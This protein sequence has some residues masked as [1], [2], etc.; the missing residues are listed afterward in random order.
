MNP[1]RRG[2]AYPFRPFAT[3]EMSFPPQ[4]AYPMPEGPMPQGFMPEGPTPGGFMPGIPMSANS[5]PEGPMPESFMPGDQMPERQEMYAPAMTRQNIVTPEPPPINVNG[6][7]PPGLMG[8]I[9]DGMNGFAEGNNMGNFA[10]MGGMNEEMGRVS[11]GMGGMSEQFGGMDD[12]MVGMNN[13]VMGGMKR[14]VPSFIHEGSRSVKKTNIQPGKQKKNNKLAKS[15]SNDKFESKQREAEQKKS[16]FSGH[17]HMKPNHGHGGKAPNSES[18]VSRLEIW[19]DVVDKHLSKAKPHKKSHTK[20]KF[21]KRSA[22]NHNHKPQTKKSKLHRQKSKDVSGSKKNSIVIHRPPI[23]YHPPPEIYHRPDIVVHRAPIMLHRPP[24]VYHQPPVVV[25]R[26]AI[27]YH[28]PEIVFHQPPPVVHQPVLQ[29]HDTWVTRPQIVHTTSTM[30]HSHTYFGIPDHV[31]GG[32]FNCQGPHCSYRKHKIPRKSAHSVETKD[33]ERAKREAYADYL[34]YLGI[35]WAPRRKR[36]IDEE[37]SLITSPKRA[38]EKLTYSDRDELHPSKRGIDDEYS[39]ITSPKNAK[40]RLTYTD[41]NELNPSKR[42]NLDDYD[43]YLYHI[44]NPN[45][46]HH[47]KNEEPRKKKKDVVVNRPPI[48]YHPPPEIYHRPDIVVHRPPLVI[49]RPP[50]IYHQPPVIVHRP[51]VVYHQPPIV[52]HQPPPAVS[53]PLLYSHDSFTVSCLLHCV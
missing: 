15:T 7:P 35:L 5:V 45:I 16:K 8:N 40:E 6:Y 30:S 29:S 12:R 51:A 4:S 10:Q 28:Q 44:W 3:P 14:N 18:H 38:K 11:N 25:H 13:G 21:N 46:K 27:I 26:P 37:Y 34:T 36:Y 41:K 32:G 22:E 23:I 49:H 42:D 53:Q 19:Q 50:I 24:I 48:I 20:K 33:H 1:Y 2:F 31:Y 43:T 39:L 47:N 52:F 9:N 17:K